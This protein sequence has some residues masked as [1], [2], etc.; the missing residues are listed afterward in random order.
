[1]PE[2]CKNT[3][4]RGGPGPESFKSEHELK[5]KGKPKIKRGER[6]RGSHPS[7]IAF[8]TIK[9]GFLATGTFEEKEVNREWGF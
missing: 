3:D 2:Y 6:G 1:M 9:T 8:I 4:W 5:C 7:A